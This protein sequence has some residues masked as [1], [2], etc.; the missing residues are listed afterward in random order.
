MAGGVSNPDQSEKKKRQHRGQIFAKG[1]D[2]Q[3]ADGSTKVVEQEKSPEAIA[4][5]RKALKKSLFKDVEESDELIDSI[6]QVMSR[7]KVEAGTP[8]IVEG[9]VGHEYYVV[10]EGVLEFSIKENVVGSVSAGGSFGELAL[11]YDAPR[12]ATA[13]ASVLSTLWSLGRDIF[14]EIQ[15]RAS[16]N[17]QVKRC[18]WLKKVGILQS[19]TPQQLSRVAGALNEMEFTTGDRI[20]NQ[21]D[22]GDA[23]Y[24]IEFGEVICKRMSDGSGVF[25]NNEA[26]EEFARLKEGDY[27]GEAALLTNQP[28]NASI[29]AEGVVKCLSL[30]VTLFNEIMGPLAMLMQSNA[31]VR[32]IK[33][34]SSSTGELYK[35]MLATTAIHQIVQQMKT[36]MYKDGEVVASPQIGLTKFHVVSEK[37][38][39]NGKIL[40]PGGQTFGPGD[41]F[42]RK[43]LNGNETEE[44][45]GEYFAEGDTECMAISFKDIPKDVQNRLQHVAP[46]AEKK[47]AEANKP[48]DRRSQIKLSE[49][50]EVGLLGQGSF[51]KVTLVSI[52]Y[53][54]GDEE[55]LA[56]KC[57]SKAHVVQCGQAKHIVA[58]KEILEELPCH[59]FVL[60]LHRT[61]QDK[62]CV[63]MLTE[64]I[65]G[66]E[67]FNYLHGDL[68]TGDCLEEHGARFY[69]SNVFLALEHLHKFDIVYRDLKPENL[70]VS[71]TGYLKVIDL[72]FAKKIP[73]TTWNDNGESEIHMKSFTLCGTPEYLAPEFIL[74]LGHDAAV[75]YWAIGILLYEFLTGQ[76]PFETEDG[77]MNE[78][79]KNIA[80]MRTGTSR[81]PFPRGF[82]QQFPSAADIISKLLHGNP[83]K[84]LG[85]L[86]NGSN[87]IRNHEWFE[88]LVWDDI[89]AKKTSNE[90]PFIPVILGARDLS[91][92]EQEDDVPL[93]EVEEYDDPGSTLFDGF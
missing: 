88:P 13:T 83:S 32:S 73:H 55:I 65:Q 67:L 36:V 1:L 81:V 14:R 40:V 9:E 20:M 41:C 2:Q 12:A 43:I 69:S 19:L 66:G 31:A 39:G 5:I 77:S 62:N 10:E 27:F 34:C 63:Y 37:V 48:L 84:R 3:K 53:K 72:G 82:H 28:R 38:G 35:D 50:E 61:F 93:L 80:V 17:S 92:F 7:I 74:N 26:E 30:G 46:T 87:D 91:N 52:R 47:K 59:P 33:V 71:E 58:E 25:Q 76:T 29:V 78:L 86:Y 49:M 90:P 51:G 70:M 44:V 56:L 11:I 24:I 42:G 23:F 79:F 89:F 15:A 21:G 8:V 45:G 4:A 22:A 16:S 68:G 54:E 85:M 57:M 64:L 18:Q 75:D 60:Q 6:I